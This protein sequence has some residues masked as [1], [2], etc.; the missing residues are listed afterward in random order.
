MNKNLAIA[1]IAVAIVSF[2]VFSTTLHHEFVNWDDDVYVTA[3]PRIQ[4]LS[5]ENIGWF[6]S[7]S[8]FYAYIPV[9][10]LSHAIDFSVWGPNPHGHHLTNIILHSLNTVWLLILGVVL[11][12]MRKG[13]KSV[14]ETSQ[15]DQRLSLSP[16][17]I[18]MS[19]AALL[20]SLHP[21]RAESVAWVSDRKDLLCM[22]FLIPSIL[23]YFHFTQTK[24]TTAGNRWYLLSFLLFVAAV[25][26]K[27]IAVTLPALLVLFDWLLRSEGRLRGQIAM[28]L[29]E[30]IPFLAVSV[31]ITLF[32]LS[33][34]PS[35][36]TSYVVSHLQGIERW[37]FPFSSL[38]FYLE[39]TFMPIDL[40]PLYP[41]V[42]IWW[43][44][45]CFLI[46]VA[47]T[48]WCFLMAR[49]NKPGLAVAWLSYIILLI[50][51]VV[52]LSSG[53]QPVA[54]RYSYIS[55]AGLYIVAGAVF[56]GLWDAAGKRS[57]FLLLS[58]SLAVCIL[59]AAL[60]IH[61]SAYWKTSETLW[62]S[63]IDRFAVRPEY[64]D[65]YINL[66]TAYADNQRFDDAQHAFEKALDVDPDNADAFYNLGYISYVQNDPQ[67]AVEMFGKVT[68]LDPTS[69]KAFY[70]LAIAYSTL[71]RDDLAIP[72]MQEAAR[73]G[74]SDAQEALRSRGMSWDK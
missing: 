37:L 57:R 15:G 71:G 5:T 74:M 8:Y 31:A 39:K 34:S 59:L 28:F 23:A 18:G 50:P 58:G 19:L 11:M 16:I 22:F 48:L 64:G 20:F 33:F 14:L 66:G 12:G 53:M 35:G 69:A 17:L 6:F 29:K 65:A 36:K 67:R 4:P 43:M 24:G 27:S 63:V 30:K 68:Q 56:S 9:T 26:S 1:G 52:G 60:S 41:S 3:N 54:D 21:L 2:G 46:V 73:L 38:I 61:Q 70:N 51:T 72:A 62:S 49:R 42:S 40:A 44:S 25:L 45:L 13:R 10:M 47:V 32:S 55:T 7:N